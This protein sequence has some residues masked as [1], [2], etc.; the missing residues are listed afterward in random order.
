MG[1]QEHGPKPKQTIEFSS[2]DHADTSCQ[3]RG[4]KTSR[5]KLRKSLKRYGQ[6]EPIK[7]YPGDRGYI[8]IDGHSRTEELKRFGRTT[9]DVIIYPVMTT[10]EARRLAFEFNVVRRNLTA[11]DKGSIVLAAK[12]E[13]VS[14][15]VTADTYGLP[16]RTVQRYASIPEAILEHF[17]GHAVTYS[18]CK[19][20]AEAF[21]DLPEGEIEKVAAEI[22]ERHLSVRE[23]RSALRQ[24]GILRNR[25]GRPLEIGLV[26]SDGVTLRSVTVKRDAPVEE[27]ESLRDLGQEMVKW[28]IKSI[29]ER[30]T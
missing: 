29:E 20:L 26:G 4:S 28:A 24:R 6:L 21:R 17:D 23:L 22:K 16:L 14:S 30:R 10:A 1:P 2:I 8:I 15:E 7:V 3:L 13:G 9:I 5:R 27:L 25:V 11:T 18:H 19:A 12:K